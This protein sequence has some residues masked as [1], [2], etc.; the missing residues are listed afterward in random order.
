M[1][2]KETILIRLDIDESEAKKKIIE[3]TTAIRNY[4]TQNRELAKSLKAGKITEDDYTKAL[5]ANKSAVESLKSENKQLELSMKAS[6]NSV[7]G[8]RAKIALLTKQ[9]NQLDMGSDK[10]RK[11]QAELKK[12]N[13]ELINIGE[14]RSDFRANVGNY[15]SAVKGFENRIEELKSKLNTLDLNTKEYKETR[16]EI[17]KVT[18]ELQNLQNGVSGIEGKLNDFGNK[19]TGISSGFG[20]L[21]TSLKAAFG[22]AAI[23]GGVALATGALISLKMELDATREQVNLLTGATGDALDEI[24]A[25]V[26]ATASTFDKDFN[27]TLLTANTVAAQFGIGIQEA[28]DL[29]Q[30]GFVN[31][32]DASGNFLADLTEFSPQ[33]NAIGL[34]A[35]QAIAI[36]SQQPESGVFSNKGIDAI[37]EAGIRLKEMPQ[38]A[39][40]ALDAIGLSSSGIQKQI[41]DGT[42]TTFDAIQQ[43]SGKLAELPATSQASAQA[44]ADI[45]GSAGQD[46]GLQYLTTL[47]E[48]ET[49]LDTL[50]DGAGDFAKAN[51]QI[52]DAQERIN[53]LFNQVLGGGGNMF[54]ELKGMALD[55]VANA[56]EFIVNGTIEIINWF[57]NL[58]NESLLFRGSIQAIKVNFENTWT[59]IKFIFNQFVDQLKNAGALIQAIFTG[60][61]SAIPDLL[62]NAFEGAVDNVKEFG[63][64]VAGNYK[65]AIA[66]TLNPAEILKPIKLTTDEAV[67]AFYG[68]GLASGAAFNEGV[69]MTRAEYLKD[70]QAFL[71]SQLLLTEKN[72]Q[73]QLDIKLRLIEIERDIELEA[74][75]LTANQKLLIQTEAFV[76]QQEAQHEHYE[77]LKAQKAA[78][79]AEEIAAIE[80]GELRKSLALQLQ[81]LQREI[82]EQTFNENLFAIREEALELEIEQLEEGTLAKMEKEVE[83]AELRAERINEAKAKEIETSNALR[84]TEIANDEARLNS[85]GALAA[86]LQAVAGEHTV[87]AKIAAGISKGVTLGQMTMD[88]QQELAAN[89]LAGAKISAM[90]PPATVPAGVTYTTTRNIMAG[91]RFGAGVAKVGTSM[92]EHG[93]QAFA[94]NLAFSGGH[95]PRYGG[96][97]SGLPHGQGGV[98]FSMG[99]SRI[100]E[101]D[102]R[103]GEAYI[104]N[105]RKSPT[106]KALASAI[107]VAG[108]GRSFFNMGGVAHFANGGVASG[109]NA[110]SLL[111]PPATDFAAILENLP[112]PVVLVDDI[113]NGTNRKIEV[114]NGAIL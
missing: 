47:K 83:L 5:L 23:V 13:D 43:V 50:T 21:G 69:K 54:N 62:Q 6:E 112:T 27:E 39:K 60:N 38:S 59:A 57:R 51:L 102:G 63:K 81:F 88:L 66:E 76:A 4:A 67:T 97:I 9:A 68:A 73:E 34:S 28:T 29:I 114:E 24:T 26:S 110:G 16:D 101:A 37:K 2:K 15:G 111:P 7:E 10:Y 33:F 61:F 41:Q 99:G 70:Q 82:D 71:Q 1:A 45:F 44:V 108:G 53:M 52:V 17:A 75:G 109:V 87:A 78:Q 113:V 89:A 18:G 95:M 80:D 25:K 11:A 49:N 30:K 105:T 86:G 55:F 79:L 64:E 77:A 8:L 35:D 106:L 107:N 100:G 48:I 98:K 12:L 20:N 96:M 31:G 56:L 36:M 84:E 92:F 32:A 3:N 42:I 94:D 40:D 22:P 72:S 46:A 90:A 65:D 74:E 58:Y 93:G 19:L 91:V 104:V 103:K 14:D 85:A